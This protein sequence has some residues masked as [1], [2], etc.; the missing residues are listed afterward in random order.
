M[1]ASTRPQLGSLP[2]IAALKRLFARDGTPHL[3]GVVLGCRPH[4]LDRDVVARALRVGLQ[5]TREVEAE[6]GERPAERVGVGSHAGGAGREEGHLVVR[7]HAAVGVEPVEAVARREAQGGIRLGRFEVG[8]GRDDHEHRRE[9]GRE[10]PGAFAMPP[11]TQPSPRRT[12][13][14]ETES[15]VMIARAASPPPAVVRTA[16]ASSRRRAPS[17]GTPRRPS[18]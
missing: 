14:L 8:I 18:R 17:L 16:S 4:D 2:K 10:H 7:R 12:A 13:C 6:L 3:D 11:M 5:L 15:V 1:A 9:P